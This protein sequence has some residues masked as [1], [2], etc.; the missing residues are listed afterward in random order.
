[1]WP[2]RPAP[3]SGAPET[4]ASSDT[5]A[6]GVGGHLHSVDE[7]HSGPRVLGEQQVAVEVDVVAERCDAAPCSDPEPR[8]DHATKHHPEHKRARSMRHTRRLADAAGL[9][10]L[11]R[12]AVRDLRAPGDI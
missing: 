12:D 8:L 2:P 5:E 1:H 4:R 3:V 9:R 7:L 11:D 10:E 6:G